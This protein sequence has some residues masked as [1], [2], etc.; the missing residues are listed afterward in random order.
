MIQIKLGLVVKNHRNRWGSIFRENPTYECGLGT[1]HIMER[2][3]LAKIAKTYSSII[4]NA[5]DNHDREVASNPAFHSEVNS[6]FIRLKIPSLSS[7]RF[8]RKPHGKY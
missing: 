7:K 8:R 1:P 2:P 6:N 5:L 4:Q 3:V